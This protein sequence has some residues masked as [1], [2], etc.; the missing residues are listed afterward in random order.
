V[1]A[2]PRRAAL[3]AAV[4]LLPCAALVAAGVFLDGMALA[5]AVGVISAVGLV[6]VGC[7]LWGAGKRNRCTANGEGGVAMLEFAMVFPIGLILSLLMVQSSLLMVGNLCVNYA[8][9]CAARCAIVTV[10]LNFSDREPHNVVAFGGSSG[11]TERIRQAAVWAVMPVSCSAPEITPL[12]TTDLEAGLNDLF[13]SYGV[14]TPSWVNRQLR[15]RLGYADEHTS[16]DVQPPANGD[17]YGDNEDVRVT[18]A[19]T[20]YMAVPYA[21]SIYAAM[22]SQNAVELGFAAGEYGLIIRSSQALVNHG[23]AD[24]IEPETFAE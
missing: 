23:V 5:M 9:Y 24:F 1:E 20:F 21:A 12:A 11:K 17:V 19:H 16:V 6:A 10:P 3:G 2:S 7:V 18:V 8:A 13:S 15:H 22:D 4:C 14:E